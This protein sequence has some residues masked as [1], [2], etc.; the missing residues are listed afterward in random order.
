MNQ[1]Q[2]VRD[3][4]FNLQS[5]NQLKSERYSTSEV[6]MIRGGMAALPPHG[7]TGVTI[8]YR[9]DGSQICEEEFYGGAAN[10]CTRYYSAEGKLVGQDYYRGGGVFCHHVFS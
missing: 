10:G 8:F 7:F 6:H 1:Y 9:Q 5:T 2:R 4:F 3:E